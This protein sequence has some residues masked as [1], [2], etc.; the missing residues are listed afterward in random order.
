MWEIFHRKCAQKLTEY[1]R[2]R[3]IKS[4]NSS[5]TTKKIDEKKTEIK[6]W[7]SSDDDDGE[8]IVKCENLI[9]IETDRN[10]RRAL[11]IFS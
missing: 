10:W 3:E 1:Q 2:I 9:E 7:R 11:K 5:R 4:F 6:S 8:K